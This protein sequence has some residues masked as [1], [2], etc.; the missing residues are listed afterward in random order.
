[1]KKLLNLISL[2][3]SGQGVVEYALILALIVLTVI[4]G[5]NVLGEATNN[6]Y[7]EALNKMP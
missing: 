1:M 3:E 2:E 5:L 4:V 6:L 7:E